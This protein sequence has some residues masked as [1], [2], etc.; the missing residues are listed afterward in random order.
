M[1]RVKKRLQDPKIDLIQAS[2]D[3]DGLNR[4]IDLKSKDIIKNTARSASE[5]CEKWNLSLARVRRKKMMP[6]ESG[7]DDGLSAIEEM[8]RIMNEI[9]N[10]LKTELSKRSAAFVGS[11]TRFPS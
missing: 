4:I 11:L 10:R 1:Q 5:Y 2:D 3:L 9:A 7:K 6:G 8:K